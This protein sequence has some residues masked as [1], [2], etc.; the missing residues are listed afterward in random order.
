MKIILG[1]LLLLIAIP[2]FS[3]VA[4]A[5]ITLYYEIFASAT[6]EELLVGL[7]LAA[8]IA[9]IVLVIYRKAIYHWFNESR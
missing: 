1:T 3:G 8:V 6:K 7:A 2:L 9:V 4:W 5:F